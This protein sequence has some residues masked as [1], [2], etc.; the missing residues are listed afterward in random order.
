M[1]NEKDRNIEYCNDVREC[2]KQASS[3]CL[4]AFNGLFVFLNPDPHDRKE[5][6]SMLH[7]LNEA[8]ALIRA[9]IAALDHIKKKSKFKE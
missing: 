4:Y 5:Y 9:S 6:A 8:E 3:R 7:N 1:V 2:L